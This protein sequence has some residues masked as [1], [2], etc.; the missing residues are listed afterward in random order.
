MN[1]EDIE[2][3]LQEE[4]EERIELE[5]EELEALKK[6]V[7]SGEDIEGYSQTDTK[8]GKGDLSKRINPASFSS[9]QQKQKDESSKLKDFSSLYKSIQTDGEFDISQMS[10]SDRLKMSRFQIFVAKIANGD[11]FSILG[12]EVDLSV[13]GDANTKSKLPTKLRI[14]LPVIFD[15]SYDVMLLLKTLNEFVNGSN[16][17]TEAEPNEF[18]WGSTY[19]FPIDL[20]K[21]VSLPIY[22]RKGRV[23]F[24]K[25]VGRYL[26]GARDGSGRARIPISKLSKTKLFGS[27]GS[28][29][30][31]E[32]QAY[33]LAKS[34]LDEIKMRNEGR[35]LTFDKALFRVKDFVMKVESFE[36]LSGDNPLSIKHYNTVKADFA[37]VGVDNSGQEVYYWISHKDGKTSRDFRSWKTISGKDAEKGDP[38]LEK[39]I[40]ALKAWIASWKGNLPS[41]EDRTYV[42]VVNQI[43]YFPKGETFR[44]DYNN[45]EEFYKKIFGSMAG[46][47]EAGKGNENAVDCVIQGSFE[48][49][50]TDKR[51]G[52][53]EIGLK[54]DK[55]SGRGILYKSETTPDTLF[56]YIEGKW[57]QDYRPALT[58]YHSSSRRIFGIEKCEIICEPRRR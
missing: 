47:E 1:Y 27:T 9:L 39:F 55:G 7:E 49:V 40:V 46:E 58:A 53:V 29:I 51:D 13:V 23:F 35:D 56:A 3:F 25:Y 30:E 37:I 45:Q 10:N 11:P 14:E 34:S 8:L 54:V 4:D 16:P 57:G 24:E 20:Q 15:N 2:L 38:E 44:R 36:H 32:I 28:S 31:K 42:P 5:P 6:A 43:Y 18:K 50:Q 12:P 26:V 41:R 33:L 19:A 48:F 52:L 21:T 22:Q 17:D